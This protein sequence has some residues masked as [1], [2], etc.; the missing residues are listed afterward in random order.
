[1]LARTSG[2]CRPVGPRGA[3]LRDHL[4]R[5]AVDLDERQE[6]RRDGHGD[7]GPGYPEEVIAGTATVMSDTVNRASQRRA[8]EKEAYAEPQAA[9]A[10]PPP[11]AYGPAAPACA[12]PASA[13]R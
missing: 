5:A 1:M 10:A 3:E 13:G 8:S 11:P 4:V 7:E 6:Q 9:A 2:R 12:S